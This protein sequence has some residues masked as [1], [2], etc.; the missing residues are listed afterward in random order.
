MYQVT[1][2][3]QQEPIYLLGSKAMTRKGNV[4]IVRNVL[5]EKTFDKGPQSTLRI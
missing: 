4:T 3:R 5:F 1:I 2:I